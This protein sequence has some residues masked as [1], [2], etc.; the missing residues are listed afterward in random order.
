MRSDSASCNFGVGG[1]QEGAKRVRRERLVRDPAA[2]RQV[3]RCQMINYHLKNSHP[4]IVC[5]QRI[6]MALFIIRHDFLLA[7]FTRL[8]VCSI[9]RETLEDM[10]LNPY[11][12]CH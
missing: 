3:L 9:S 8:F 10:F 11:V 4:N 6:I 1:I 7:R 12:L 2:Q 5:V